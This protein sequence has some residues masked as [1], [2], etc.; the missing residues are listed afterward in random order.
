MQLPPSLYCDIKKTNMYMY[1]RLEEIN[2]Y[3]G[4]EHLTVVMI[5]AKT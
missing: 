4:I 1:E 2:I 5:V 3:L